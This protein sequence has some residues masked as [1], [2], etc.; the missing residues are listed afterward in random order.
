M[1]SRP[2]FGCRD[3]EPVAGSQGRDAHRQVLIRRRRAVGVA[4]IRGQRRAAA[5]RGCRSG[6]DW[7]DRRR[8][9]RR[10]FR[11]AADADNDLW[12]CSSRCYEVV[13][14]TGNA[15][16]ATAPAVAPKLKLSGCPGTTNPCVS[17]DGSTNEYFTASVGSMVAQ[18]W[19]FAVVSDRTVNA[20][21]SIAA[22]GTWA[23]GYGTSANTAGEY[24]GSNSSTVPVSDNAIHALAFLENGSSST[25]TVDG[26]ATNVGANGTQSITSSFGVFANDSGINKLGG[27][28]FEI[29]LWPSSIT[30]ALHSN[31]SAHYGSP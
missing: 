27:Y 25:V 31:Q 11:R 24:A 4:G 6:F 21:L 12:C 19:S 29:G 20:S 3:G 22:S 14:Q 30:T 5:E 10:D 16:H 2:S 18:P 28:I 26:T 8:A 13:C 15:I 17:A 7:L 23:V 9:A 1:R